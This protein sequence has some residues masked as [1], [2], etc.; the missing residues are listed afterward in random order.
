MGTRGDALAKPRKARGEPKRPSDASPTYSPRQRGIYC[1]T[2]GGYVHCCIGTGAGQGPGRR[3]QAADQQ[4]LDGSGFRPHFPTINPATGEEIC[5][6]AEADAADVDAAVKAARDAFEH[7]PWR[8]M[9][10]SER[11]T[12][13]EPAG[14]SDRK[15]CRRTGP[16]G[17]RWTTASPTW[18]RKA[19]DLPLTIACYRYY[20]RLGRQGSGQDHSDRRAITSAT[21]GI[22]PVGVVGQI[23]PWNFP[24][25][26]QAWKL[27]P[28]LACGNT[29]VMKPAEQTPLTR[30]ARRRTDRR[31]RVPRRRGQYSARLWSDRGP[32]DRAAHGCRQGRVHRLDRS[33]PPD[34]GSGGADQPQARHAGTGRQESRTSS[35]PTPIWIRRSKARTSRCSSIRASAAAPARGCSSSARST[36]SSSRRSVDRAKRRTVGDPFDPK[37]EQGPQVDEAQFDKV[38]SYIESGEREGAKLVCG[39]G[40]GRRPRLLHPAD[41]VRRRAG[42]HEDRPGRDLR[43][44]DEHHPVR[45]HRRGG[46]ARQPNDV[47]L[48]RRRLDARHRQ[49]ASPLPTACAPARCG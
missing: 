28:A 42:R 39:G 49:G 9:A 40:S 47:R 45:K 8:R 48:G 7:G 24:L 17:E 20:R 44:G 33:R 31:S 4:P 34:H 32:G 13:A 29:V 16:A 12:P 21:R 36:T 23:I 11:G 35:S 37:T 46:R 5:Q 27:A 30:A 25:L 10:A 43:T 14:R 2:E 15:A 41:G 26:M 3:N 18:W 38:M 1:R 22:E 6:V 19:A